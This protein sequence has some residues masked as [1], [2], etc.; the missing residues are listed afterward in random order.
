MSSHGPA[1]PGNAVIGG[2][3]GAPVPGGY[4]DPAVVQLVRQLRRTV[5]SQAGL[6]PDAVEINELN[7][8]DLHRYGEAGRAPLPQVGESIMFEQ[9][10]RIRLG[11]RVSD[12]P[13][14]SFSG[15]QHVAVRWALLEFGTHANARERNSGVLVPISSIRMLL[16]AR[17]Y[18]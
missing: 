15:V 17:Q 6:R 5:S 11:T 9:N 3:A 14:R 10:G 12:P 7:W 2:G 1:Q 18:T 8:N 13:A 16:D 4:D